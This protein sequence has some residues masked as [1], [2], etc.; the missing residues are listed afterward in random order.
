MNTVSAMIP[1]ASGDGLS[2]HYGIYHV[3]KRSGENHFCGRNLRLNL[4]E[5]LK[6]PTASLDADYVYTDPYGDKHG[7]QE[8]F[9]TLDAQNKR[10]AVNKSDVTVGLDGTLKNS[11]GREVFKEEVSDTGWRAVTKLVGVKGVDLYEQRQSEIKQLE[12]KITQYEDALKDFVL[13]DPQ[14]GTIQNKAS[15]Y[16]SNETFQTFIDSISGNRIPLTTNEALAYSSLLL[17]KDSLQNQEETYEFQ[18]DP[19]CKYQKLACDHQYQSLADSL[20]I[21][22]REQEKKFAD[23][24]KI[25]FDSWSKEEQE[26][27]IDINTQ[28]TNLNNQMSDVLGQK[29]L[30][31]GQDALNQAASS[32]TTAQI[33]HVDEQ[34]LALRNKR[35]LYTRQL[36]QYYKEYVNMS[37][38]LVL[39]K[40]FTPINYLT[41]GSII[42]GFNEDGDLVVIGDGY[43]NTLVIERDDKGRILRVTDDKEKSV[44]FAYNYYD[45]LVSITDARGR[46]TCYT[47]DDG[48]TEYLRT[49][50]YSDG[51]AL[52]LTGTGQLDAVESKYERTALTYS[53]TR[54]KGLRHNS[55]FTAVKHGESTSGTTLLSQLGIEYADNR[56]KITDVENAT[57]EMYEFDT[58]GNA[59]KYYVEAHGL[60]TKAEHYAYQKYTKDN[61]EY[62]KP[63]ILHKTSL[64]AFSFAKEAYD[65]TTLDSFNLPSERTTFETL[66]TNTTRTTQTEYTYDDNRRV[67]KEY[68]TVTTSNSPEDKHAVKTVAYNDM[69]SVVRTES[70]VE[71]E[72]VGRGKTVEETVY[73]DKGRAVKSFTYNTLDTSSKYYNENE[74]DENGKVAAEY[75][76][77][78]ENKTLVETV[79][80]TETVRTRTL[81]NGS[82]F[83]YGYDA[84][85]RVTAITQST[86]EGEEN[87]TQTAYTGGLVTEVKSGNNTVRYSYDGKGRKTAVY[88]ND[89]Q[90]PYVA[91]A[92]EK[93][94]NGEKIA[95][96]LRNGDAVH[97]ETD[98]K[99]NV[100]S[101]KYNNVT[102]MTAS[103]DSKNRA[104]QI[105]DGVTGN[106]VATVY[107]AFDRIDAVKINNVETEKYTYNTDG[108]LSTKTVTVGD[109]TKR[110]EYGYKDNAAKDL[111][112]ITVDGVT[113]M[114]Q[115][116]CLGRNTGKRIAIGGTDIAEEHISYRK[117]G[118]HATSMPSAERYG[119][120]RNG[121][122]VL[123]D[124]RKYKYDAC[125]NIS[126]VWENGTLAAKYT[127]DA[128]NRLIREDNKQ[129]GNTTLYTYDNNGNILSKRAFAFTL[130]DTALLEEM[131]ETQ[132]MQ[133]AYSGDK[134]LAFGNEHF[135]Y[136]GMGNPTTYRDKA[137]AWEK[138]R[139]LASYD[140]TTFAYDGQGRRIRK[141]T[142]QYTYDSNGNLLKQADGENTLEFLYDH[143]GLMGVK[144]NG[145]TYLYRKNIMGDVIAILDRAGKIVVRYVYDAWGNHEV[146]ILDGT[147]EDKQ[148]THIGNLNP[149]RYRGYYYD[150]ETGLYF[151]KTRYYD[152]QI[153]RFIT[154]DDIQYL[155]P[156]HI[157]GLNLY[158]YCG[159]N[160]VMNIDPTGTE[161][162]TIMAIVAALLFSTFMGTMS[163]IAGAAIN[164]RHIGIGAAIG[165]IGGLLNGVGLVLGVFVHPAISVAM[166]VT[167]GLATE[168]FNQL[169]NHE[170]I[171]VENILYTGILS[172]ITGGLSY[173]IGVNL[174][175][176]ANIAL[177]YFLTPTFYAIQTLCDSLIGIFGNPLSTF[178]NWFQR[179]FSKPSSGALSGSGTGVG[180]G[181]GGGGGSSW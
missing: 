78:G 89:L 57:V 143:S 33:L 107:D 136:D 19:S 104:T 73:D 7:F 22:Q 168:Y 181:F 90:T 6:K 169:F 96:T 131:S 120:M 174:T 161:P 24:I 144:H 36:K 180:G 74:L 64:S 163:G 75:D 112:S 46:M 177:G 38:E 116:D 79:E 10:V 81:R 20:K 108:N 16:V 123:L 66:D 65:Y 109:S 94:T 12:D 179:F 145:N 92:Y 28:L 84:S 111:D 26:E 61:T 63:S 71:E 4:D 97:T 165:A 158:A 110:Y 15:D 88:L 139:Q 147:P 8:K 155:D 129:R 141:N 21:A 154:I 11:A 23:K 48:D 69:G 166:A 153:C 43:Q 1:A 106:T 85:E 128:L 3:Y 98:K 93:D 53:G 37:A 80:G 119:E 68:A 175:A 56:T 135:E 14:D 50:T 162:I 118:D 13:I 156:E 54:L 100:L 45:R 171:N 178:F 70:Y 142:T 87:S 105:V 29:T 151:L 167:V 95:A 83:A 117:V 172:G 113:V 149:F 152:P 44:T 39:R 102:Q 30:L 124:N 159:D 34:L 58:T 140:E 134:L 114:P 126:E 9:Y 125:G 99:G 101:V 146:K 62:A 121:A 51:S 91:Y 138:G 176:F 41:D 77:T 55:L 132:Y 173:A 133:Y 86:A 25:P 47:Y 52:T 164:N 82:K 35:A 40:R 2:L 49:V 18:H 157:N 32:N 59:C 60:V 137:C 76:T 67:V 160:P 5:K 17:Q 27:F 103:Y 148:A 170:S 42:K 115:S 31:G 127:Y 72:V 150:V 122:F 130:K